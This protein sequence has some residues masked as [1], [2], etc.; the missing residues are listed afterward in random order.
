MTRKLLSLMTLPVVAILAACGGND[1]KKLDDALRQDLTLASQAY[2][3]QA[4]VSPQEMGY[5]GAPR[6][7]GGYYPTP[8]ATR[9]PSNGGVI[10][11][12]PSSSGTVAQRTRVVKQTKRDAVIGAAAGA[13]VG[14]VTS[15]DKLKGAV[16]GAAAGGI[17]GA[18][19][20]NNV[21]KKKV[22]Y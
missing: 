10:R 12:A 5:N 2:P 14:A 4:F 15:R 21:D 9:Y 18:V 11:R 13:A 6:T 1:A 17:L 3:N 22:P 16:I 7:A 8:V 19:F 20:G